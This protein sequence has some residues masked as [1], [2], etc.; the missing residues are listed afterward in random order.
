MQAVLNA[1][2]EH[3]PDAIWALEAKPDRLEFSLEWLAEH[4]YI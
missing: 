1:L 3:A 2:E 4:D